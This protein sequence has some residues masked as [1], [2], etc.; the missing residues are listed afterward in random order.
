MCVL[1]ECSHHKINSLLICKDDTTKITRSSS[2]KCCCLIAFYGCSFGRENLRP[3]DLPRRKRPACTRHI[4]WP[5]FLLPIWGAQTRLLNTEMPPRNWCRTNF[6]DNRKIRGALALSQGRK[7]D[8]FLTTKCSVSDT[9]GAH[10]IY[11]PLVHMVLLVIYL[12]GF[13]WVDT[14]TWENSN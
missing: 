13:P 4:M 7:S 10:S 11:G 14:W 2:S 12:V 1:E 8:D 5:R 6:L 3:S 9:S